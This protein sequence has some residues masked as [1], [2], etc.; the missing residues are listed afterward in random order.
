MSAQPSEWRYDVRHLG[1]ARAAEEKYD[2]SWLYESLQGQQDA[3]FNPH[4]PQGEN[5]EGFVQ[6]RSGEQLLISACFDCGVREL[7]GANRLPKKCGFPGLHL[8]H[9]Q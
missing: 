5:V 7:K 2:P 8:H 3:D 9:P 1:T 6:F 4:G